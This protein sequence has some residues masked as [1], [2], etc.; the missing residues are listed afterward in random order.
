MFSCI[1]SSRLWRTFLRNTLYL[2]QIFISLRSHLQFFLHFF[3]TFME[4]LFK[5]HPISFSSKF[6]RY[7]VIVR[8]I[9]FRSCKKPYQLKIISTFSCTFPSFLWKTFLI[10]TVYVY[11]GTSPPCP[12]VHVFLSTNVVECHFTFYSIVCGHVCRRKTTIA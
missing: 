6:T 4:N 8:I 9:K 12:I 11:I 5:K 10:N 2:C 1:S 3:F 7:T